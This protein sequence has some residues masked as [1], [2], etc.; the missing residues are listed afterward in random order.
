M[1]YFV[2]G[3]LKLINSDGVYIDS[4]NPLPVSIIGT[5]TVSI[6]GT[7]TVDVDS[8]TIDELSFINDRKIYDALSL[9][10]IEL[11]KVRI[12]LETLTDERITNNDLVG[13]DLI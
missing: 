8:G 9:L 7:P 5:P 13:E 10:V 1:L 12:L 3:N 6:S 11:T 2:R 4:S